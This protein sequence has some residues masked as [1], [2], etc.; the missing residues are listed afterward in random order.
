MPAFKAKWVNRDKVMA[1][2]RKVLP[3]T[4]ERLA[5]A[6]AQS[7]EALADAIRSRAPVR[8]GRYRASINAKRLGGDRRSYG[9]DFASQTK[10]PNAMGIFGS[11][12]WHWLEFGT[13]KMAAEPHVF[14]TYRARK[15]SIRRA[16][17]NAVN[18]AV[19]AALT[20]KSK[21]PG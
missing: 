19:R 3:G 20:Q 15:K 6:Q 4:Q 17:A 18:R 13:Q 9:N 8:T 5:V 11:F 2:L 14:P 12:H 1:D 10:D 21:P 7:A 16:A